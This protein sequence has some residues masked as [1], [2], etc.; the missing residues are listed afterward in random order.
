L[1]CNDLTADVFETY[2]EAIDEVNSSDDKAYIIRIEGFC[3]DASP[4]ITITL[5]PHT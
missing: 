1:I 4:P 2:D 5:E 3:A